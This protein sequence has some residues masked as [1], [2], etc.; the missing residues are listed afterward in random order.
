MFYQDNQ[1]DREKWV[2]QGGAAKSLLTDFK[3]F[4]YLIKQ[5]FEC[6]NYH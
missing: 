5:S 1:T 3:V 4:G 2:E 6:L